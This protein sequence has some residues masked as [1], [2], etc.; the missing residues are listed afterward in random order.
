MRFTP[1][2]WYGVWCAW[3]VQRGTPYCG[4]Y[5]LGDFMEVFKVKDRDIKA[6]KI[7]AEEAVIESVTA[8]DSEKEEIIGDI[9][10]HISESIHC[11][12]T[13]F[14]TIGNTEPV[15]FILVKNYWNLSDFFV[16]PKYHGKGVGRALFSAARD[17]C[18]LNSE[19]GH[20]RVNSSLD[21]VGFYRKLGFIDFTPEKPVPNFVKPLI[22]NL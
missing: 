1:R 10:R 5:K 21:A 13:I 22:Y 6:L 9:H 18:R 14:L 19:R 2:F 16:C 3:L 17:L 20:I 15:G 11:E 8:S 4:R 7:L 12:D